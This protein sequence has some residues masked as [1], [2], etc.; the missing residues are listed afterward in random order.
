M[1][2][3]LVLDILLYGLLVTQYVGF[4]T[5]ISYEHTTSK[6]IMVF[7]P[8]RYPM[9]DDTFSFGDMLTNMWI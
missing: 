6:I 9:D 5:Y 7:F 8:L 1:L 3:L 4:L 2:F